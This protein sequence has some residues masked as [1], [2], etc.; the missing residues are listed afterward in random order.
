VGVPLQHLKSKTPKKMR[1]FNDLKEDVIEAIIEM[2]Q[3]FFAE[4]GEYLYEDE[5]T[6]LQSAD[7]FTDFSRVLI[8][9][10][11]WDLEDVVRIGKDIIK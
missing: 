6:K 3:E 5:L 9:M 1:K 11:Y 10:E 4:E 2:D 7:N 8:D